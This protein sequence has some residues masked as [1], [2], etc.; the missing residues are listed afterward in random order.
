MVSAPPSSPS[1]PL[2]VTP[3]GPDSLLVQWGPPD[4]DGGSPLLGFDVLIKNTEQRVW[5]EVANVYENVYW[6]QIKDLH[7]NRRYNIRVYSRNS[8]GFSLPLEAENPAQVIHP[9][10]VVVQPSPP[11]GP[12]KLSHITDTTIDVSWNPPENLGGSKLKMYVLESRNV[13]DPFT[14]HE[15]EVVDPPK[16]HGVLQGLETGETYILRVYAENNA[17]L[18]DPLIHSSPVRIGRN[19]FR[20]SCPGKPK[21]IVLERGSFEDNEK[22]DQVLEDSVILTWEAPYHDGGTSIS[23]YIIEKCVKE[24]S[25]SDC[26]E[27]A[28]FVPVRDEMYAIANL[29]EGVV[30]GFRIRAEN[31]MGVSEPSLSSKP[32]M[33]P[34]RKKIN[35][36]YFTK[37]PISVTAFEGQNVEF[38]AVILGY[39]MPKVKWYINDN[40]VETSKDI[41]ASSEEEIH[42]LVITSVNEIHKGT[43]KICASNPLCAVS[44]T[45]ELHISRFY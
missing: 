5:M 29:P 8:D 17:G 18:S 38:S 45:A 32:Y 33:V 22:F 24:S 23:T 41:Y 26:W 25:K 12:M 14:V 16:T 15:V 13:S 6:T 4:D 36:P 37:K 31:A 40:E 19:V 34:Y 10:G 7:E 35:P 1:G 28:S 3:T 44:A 20:P 27:R 30:F 21:V 42:T 2:Q 39:P 43:I 9:T 11:V